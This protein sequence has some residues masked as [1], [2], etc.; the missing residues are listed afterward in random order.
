LDSELIKIELIVLWVLLCGVDIIM[1]KNCLFEMIPSIL[2]DKRNSQIK[3]L[4]KVSGLG[5][6]LLAMIMSLVINAYYL[7]F[8]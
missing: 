5:F 8:R 7:F 2:K 3:K 1:T 4:L 6:V